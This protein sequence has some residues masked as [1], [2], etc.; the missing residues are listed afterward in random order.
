MAPSPKFWDKHAEG[1]AKSPVADE[2]SYQHK[3]AMT[4][5]Y[6]RDDSKVLELG[7]GTGSTAIVHAPHVKHILAT[8]VSPKMLDIAKSKAAA[9]NITNVTFEEATVE[10]IIVPNETYDVVMAMSLLHLLEDKEAAI[11]KVR[12]M[13]KPGGVFV[14]STVCLGETMSWFKLIGPVGKALGVF[15]LVKVFK[16]QD[17]LESLSNAGFLIDYEWRPGKGKA[18]FIVA[19][20]PE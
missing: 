12:D 17:L 16:G 9:Q 13:L 8:D 5:K 14:S 10:S 6:F 3:L 11:A 7:C 19:K 20:K 15:P 4:R 2:A 1:Y 18:M